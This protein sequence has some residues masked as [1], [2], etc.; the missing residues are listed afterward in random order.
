[1]CLCVCVCG[2]AVPTTPSNSPTWAGYPTIQ[3]NSDATY[4]ETASDSI[5][6]RL[7]PTRLPST[8]DASFRPGYHL[9]FWP[10]GH[11]SEVFIPLSLLGSI[12]LLEQ[13][14]WLRKPVYSLDNWFITKVIEGYKSTARWKDT[15]R[16]V[17][18]KGASVPV[19]CGSSTTKHFFLSY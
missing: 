7:S 11:K 16:E 5:G 8:S 17:S 1:M 12:N 14:T 19:E 10:I 2:G 6:S 3:L 15:Q 13:L 18:N 9:C 4:T